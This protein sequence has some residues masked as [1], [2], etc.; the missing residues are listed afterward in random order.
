MVLAVYRSVI[1]VALAVC[2]ASVLYSRVY[3]TF[4]RVRATVV[5]TEHASSLGSVVAS[6]PDVSRLSGQPVA[7]IFRLANGTSSVRVVRVYL[8]GSELGRITLGPNESRRIDISIEATG[9]LT[10][11]N[12]VAFVSDEDGWSVQYLELANVHGF[13]RGLFSFVI[14]PATTGSSDPVPTWVAA[15]LLV[16]LLLLPASWL[17]LEARRMPRRVYA[18]LV[19]AVLLFFFAVL[20]APVV[21][22]YKVV[23]ALHTFVFCV[24]L[25]YVPALERVGRAFLRSEVAG[26][27]M[28]AAQNKQ[29]APYL[30]CA[31]T[32]AMFFMSLAQFYDA[33]LGFTS[34]IQF[35]DQFHDRALPTVRAVPH[36]IVEDSA[37]YD[38]QFYAQL[39]VDPLVRD[40]EIAE[41]LD[42]VQYR[43]RR[44]LFSWT[45]FLFGLGQ[46]SLVLQAYAVQ[47]FVFWVLLGIV[48]FRWFPPRNIRNSALWSA[49]MFSHGLII[50]VRSALPDGPSMLFHAVAIVAI[51]CNRLTLASGLVGVSGLAKDLNLLASLVLMRTGVRWRQI[52]VATCLRAG[53]LV[54]MPLLTWIGY[55]RFMGH[56]LFGAAGI[57]N[58]A[59]P[60]SGY[61][62][63]WALTAAEL[64]E[65]GW[66]SLAQFSFLALVSLTTQ[67]IVMIIWADWKNPWWRVGIAYVLLM[68]VLGPNVWAGYPGAAPRVLLPMTFAFNIILPRNSW[69]WPLFVLGNLT[70]LHSLEVI[71]AWD[72]IANYLWV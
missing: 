45:A 14:V 28:S 66:A 58:F 25:L 62:N 54:A 12:T 65:D 31:A 56:D 59:F 27:P 30:L 33:E 42:N 40:P 36:H 21:T 35:G 72:V 13:S 46:P 1:T 71:Q 43:G 48:L 23:V 38:G 7:I 60:L 69:F 4:D 11:G 50:S 49:C 37:G 41:A 51:E 63:K 32:A 24:G 39:A 8:R 47:N 2:C 10:E 26:P 3:T 29:L 55:L 17:R 70:V 15:A 44:I 57:N 34:L 61:V 16:A 6:L 52:R 18:G 9:Q 20:L 5:R 68:V 67:A 19:V 64:T 53:A 22:Q